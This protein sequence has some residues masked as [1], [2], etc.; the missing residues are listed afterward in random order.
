MSKRPA[1]A[2]STHPPEHT[3][4]VRELAIWCVI[5]AAIAYWGEVVAESFDPSLPVPVAIAQSVFVG[6]A[7]GVAAWAMVLF[8]CNRL[9]ADRPAQKT[10]VV[11]ALGVGLLCA[12]PVRPTTALALACLG[13]WL[14]I[15]TTPTH[16]GRQAGLLLLA[17]SLSWASTCLAPIHVMVG[18]LDAHAL[19]WVSSLAGIPVTLDG[20]VATSGDFSIEILAGCTSSSQIPDVILAFVVVALYRRGALL[21][22]DLPFLL[23]AMVVSVVL[24]EIRLSFMVRGEAAYLWWHDGTGSTVYGLAA[25]ASAVAFPLLATLRSE[26]APAVQT[27]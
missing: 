24:N 8:R 14:L 12:V 25:L 11:A 16:N 2:A 15:A 19:A 1:E 17:L 23:G 4:G 27:A 3:V 26:P 21:W 22:A 18:H 10:L 5:L 13:G 9:V 20:N 6:G 7:F